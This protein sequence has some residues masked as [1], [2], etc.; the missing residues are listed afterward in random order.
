DATANDIPNDPFDVKGYPT[1]YF[2][3][4]SGKIVSYEG[5]RTKEDII[6]FIEKNRDKAGDATTEEEEKKD[7]L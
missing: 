3:S 4:A 5:D 6:D 1:I 7:E 2:R